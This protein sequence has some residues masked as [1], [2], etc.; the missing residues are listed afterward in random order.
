MRST[1][2]FV[3]CVSWMLVACG[4]GTG[5]PCETRTAGC[6]CSSEVETDEGIACAAA[7][8]GDDAFCCISTTDDSDA[9]FCTR[10]ACGRPT[11]DPDF[12]SCG[13]DLFDA[14]DTEVASCEPTAGQHCCQS[15]AFSIGALCFC[16]S[17]ECSGGDVEVSSCTTAM[18]GADCGDYAEATDRCD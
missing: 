7:D 6:V 14:T 9:C 2:L 18:V 17:L 1:V 10:P 16:S 11:D 12:C 13:P 8:Q 4:G 5:L 3:L 15:T